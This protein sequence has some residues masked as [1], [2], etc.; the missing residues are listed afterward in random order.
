LP[1]T[2][3]T[4]CAAKPHKAGFTLLFRHINRSGMWAACWQ[5][6]WTLIIW[7]ALIMVEGNGRFVFYQV[8]PG[9]Y[10]LT[11]DLPDG[12]TADIGPVVVTE[13]RGAVVGIAAVAEGKEPD[14]GFRLYLPLILNP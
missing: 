10:E 13:T 5:Y 12:L 4:N 6:K 1:A 9:S 11:A 8:E 14:D 2:S 7:Q 3:K